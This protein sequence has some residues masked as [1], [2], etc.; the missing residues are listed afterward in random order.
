M[1]ENLNLVEILKDCPQGTKLYSP[2]YGDV[3]LV[4]VLQGEDTRYPIEIKI[5]YNLTKTFTNGGRLLVDYDGECV[6]FPSKEQ[7]DWSKFKPKKP[8]FDPKTLKPFDKVLV[9]DNEEGRWVCSFYSHDR[10]YG[11]TLYRYMSTNNAYRYCIPY[12]DDTKHLVGT[13]KEAPEFYRFWED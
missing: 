13:S 8:K 6:L 2:I 5:N 1:N 12:N 10:E 7:R 3:E 4:N 9:R 11:E